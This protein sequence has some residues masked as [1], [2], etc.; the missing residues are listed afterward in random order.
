[1]KGAGDLPEKREVQTVGR[2]AISSEEIGAAL[3][4]RCPVGTT[5]GEE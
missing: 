2:T 3:T 4:K 1:M 5:E